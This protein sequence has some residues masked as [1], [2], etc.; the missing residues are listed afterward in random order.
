MPNN[1]WDR[2]PH[3]TNL[4]ET[5]HA[6][7]N[8]STQINLRLLEAI[9]QCVARMIYAKYI[10]TFDRARTLDASVAVSITAAKRTCIFRNPHDGQ[11]DRMTCS[12]THQ[13]KNAH[14]RATHQDL[15]DNIDDLQERITNASQA[16]KELRAQLKDLTE[17]KKE[18][19][20]TPRHNQSTSKFDDVKIPLI[21]G[22]NIVHGLGVVPCVRATLFDAT[23]Y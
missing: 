12:I 13:T 19:G 1:F 20:R 15:N 21:R 10:E 6:G 5:A 16:Q 4:V 7:T 14:R 8:R 3:H 17:Q 2:T 18:A 23:S 9:Q 11:I 22:L